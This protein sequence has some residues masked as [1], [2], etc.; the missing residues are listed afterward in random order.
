MALLISL[1]GAF[2]TF[3]RSSRASWFNPSIIYIHNL[4]EQYTTTSDFASI[5]GSSTFLLFLV[6]VQTDCQSSTLCFKQSFCSTTRGFFERGLRQ[7]QSIMHPFHPSRSLQILDE[8]CIILFQVS[9]ILLANIL[10]YQGVWYALHFTTA[11]NSHVSMP[12]LSI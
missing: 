9:L 4:M 6:R 3:N 8:S 5:P 12:F 2:F 10:K 11:F 1:D 7:F